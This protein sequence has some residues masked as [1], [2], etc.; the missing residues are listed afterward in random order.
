M[1]RVKYIGRW[2]GWFNLPPPLPTPCNWRLNY[3]R[4]VA[5]AGLFIDSVSRLT[6]RHYPL[7]LPP[8]SPLIAQP[9]LMSGFQIQNFHSFHFHFQSY[10]W[11]SSGSFEQLHL[12]TDERSTKPWPGRS[13]A[14]LRLNCD[15][16]GRKTVGHLSTWSSQNLTSWDIID[17]LW[18]S[19]IIID[20]H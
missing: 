16:F 1:R 12:L 17:Y 5:T 9:A 4:L 6:M 8:N 14:T 2:W 3:L 20:Y 10:S 15:Q 13:V 19:L 7:L 18:S 11:K